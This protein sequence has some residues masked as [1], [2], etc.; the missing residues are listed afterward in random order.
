MRT[1]I[2]KGSS[3]NTVAGTYP[4]VSQLGT[5]I[6]FSPEIR[7]PPH[8][9]SLNKAICNA[10]FIQPTLYSLKLHLFAYDVSTLPGTTDKTLLSGITWGAVDSLM[11]LV[12]SISF[13]PP[14][15]PSTFG[16]RPYTSYWNAD[17]DSQFRNL[18]MFAAP[19]QNKNGVLYGIIENTVETIQAS[20]PVFHFYLTVIT[21]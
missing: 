19:N 3:A 15:T 1:F 7:F 2:L 6:A 11:Y 5:P 21:P 13:G 17:P 8:S 4:A 10:G 16:S 9:V 20:A 18:E 14:W 12:A